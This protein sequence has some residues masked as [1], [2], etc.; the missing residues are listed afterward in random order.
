M[1]EDGYR[2]PDK[3]HIVIAS[4]LWTDEERA[5]DDARRKL[6]APWKAKLR[7]YSAA[8]L[9][10]VDG[11]TQRALWSAAMDQLDALGPAARQPTLRE[12]RL[13]RDYEKCLA[14]PRKRSC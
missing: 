12:E 9:R 6:R 1:I 10:G 8:L 3:A 7:E 2:R 14:R 5:S 4:H 11:D 13:G